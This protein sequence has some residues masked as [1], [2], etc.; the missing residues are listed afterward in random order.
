L[1]SP[2]W[3]GPRVGVDTGPESAYFFLLYLHRLSTL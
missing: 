3:A 1:L 2:R